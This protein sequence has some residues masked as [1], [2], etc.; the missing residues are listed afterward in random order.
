VDVERDVI[1][2]STSSS[3]SMR[4]A[5]SFTRRGDEFLQLRLGIRFSR[6]RDKQD[7]HLMLKRTRQLLLLREGINAAAC[8][9]AL[10]EK[11]RKKMAA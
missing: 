6:S 11:K 7:D 1:L 9:I 2:S 3:K 8:L 5:T 10:L 4:Q